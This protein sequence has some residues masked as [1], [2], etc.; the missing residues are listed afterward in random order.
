MP[1]PA[2]GRGGREPLP[3]SRFLSDAV[4][5]KVRAYRL[6]RRLKQDDVADRMRELRHHTWTRQTV[7][8]VE[9]VQRHLTVDELLGLSIVLD[10]S[11]NELLDPVPVG[12][13]PAA[14]L[15]VGLPVPIPPDIVPHWSAGANIFFDSEIRDGKPGVRVTAVGH[16]ADQKEERE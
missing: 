9:R 12:G 6:L 15:D 8:D 16:L 1:A 13:G 14:P 5:E 2:P 7:S 3:G 4:A 10:Q 11:L